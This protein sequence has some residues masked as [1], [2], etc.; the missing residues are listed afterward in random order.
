MVVHN[1]D[2]LVS[3]TRPQRGSIAFVN[4]ELDGCIAS[5]GFGI[6][7]D[8]DKDQVE[9]SYLWA[10]LRSEA[11]R[12]QMLQRSSGGNYPAITEDELYRVLIPLPTRKVQIKIAEEVAERRVTAS[13]FRGRAQTSWE[14]AKEDFEKELLGPNSAS[15]L[16]RPIS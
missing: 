3:L 9:A 15:R 5:T 7:T 11:G 4:E 8:I 16:G 2:I 1:G 12:L 14:D 13:H 10:F 6:L